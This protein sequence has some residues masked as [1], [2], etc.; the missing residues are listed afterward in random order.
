MVAATQADP[1]STGQ[2]SRQARTEHKRHEDILLTLP[3]RIGANGKLHP[4]K[5]GTTL[6]L[7]PRAR[8]RVCQW[9]RVAVLLGPLIE[10]LEKRS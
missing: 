3:A 6:P 1:G 8:R 4:A 2:A 10:S 5:T 7:R 9:L